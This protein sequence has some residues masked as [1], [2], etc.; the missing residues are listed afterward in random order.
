MT[1]SMK[2]LE[3][4]LNV[5]H[6]SMYRLDRNIVMFIIK[7]NPMK[8]IV[9]M[10]FCQRMMKRLGKDYNEEQNYLFLY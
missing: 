3:F 2:K 4:Y 8:Y 6:Y 9:N 1:D 5:I 10:P 7:N